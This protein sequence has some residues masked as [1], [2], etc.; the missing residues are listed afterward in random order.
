MFPRLYRLSRSN[1][2]RMC[3]AVTGSKR[4]ALV[5][6]EAFFLSVPRTRTRHPAP[7]L[8]VETLTS[9]SPPG[10]SPALISTPPKVWAAAYRFWALAGPIRPRSARVPSWQSNAKDGEEASAPVG[11]AISA[12]TAEAEAAPGTPAASANARGMTADVRR[13][14]DRCAEDDG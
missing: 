14:A 10:R 7:S 9:I 4:Y 1:S 2:T 12:H 13:L 8:L 11:G 5:V 3:E 6:I